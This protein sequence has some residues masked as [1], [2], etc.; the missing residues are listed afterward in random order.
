MTLRSALG[1]AFL[2]LVA[3][4]A[5][6]APVSVLGATTTPG[7]ASPISPIAGRPLAPASRAQTG[8]GALAH[9]GSNGP[10]VR[11]WI[12]GVNPLLEE[13]LFA[14]TY[15]VLPVHNILKVY[16][17]EANGYQSAGIRFSARV[18]HQHR[19]F[20]QDEMVDE[21][22]AL[23]KTTFETFPDIATLDVWGT[24][25]VE[26][27]QQTKYESTVFSITA[28]RTTYLALH[29]GEGLDDE[30]FVAGFGRMWVA[31]EVPR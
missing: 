10:P 5:S 1:I 20:T 11:P 25:P 27:S 13:S 4:V 31:P 9:P 16:V 26:Q 21:A 7:K 19:D 28:D 17:F 29:R 18:A 24:I 30:A 2:I 22:A 3:S 8:V 12:E 6:G 23:I 15:K 14:A